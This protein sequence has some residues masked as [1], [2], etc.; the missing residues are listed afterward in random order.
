MSLFLDR[1]SLLTLCRAQIHPLLDHSS[2]SMGVQYVQPTQLTWQV[3]KTF[4][5]LGREDPTHYP[6]GN[7]SNMHG[8]CTLEQGRSMSTMSVSQEAI[9][10]AASH[11]T[12]QKTNILSISKGMITLFL[13]KDLSWGAAV[14]HCPSSKNI[15]VRVVGVEINE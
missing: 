7:D 6:S 2:T 11:L 8:L 10:Q 13:I 5:S 15:C 4:C 3:A 14:E 1:R 9:P 12:T